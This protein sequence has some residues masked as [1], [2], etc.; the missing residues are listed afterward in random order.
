M[1]TNVLMIVLCVA[2][3]AFGNGGPFVLKYPGGDPAAKGVLARLGPGLLPG[4][5]T[6]LEVVKEDLSVTSG[7]ERFGRRHGIA[8]PPLATVEA[9]YHIRNPLAE[10]VE[11]DFGFPI[12]R[13]IY[14]SPYSMM[15]MP[16]VN[17]KVN[18]RHVQADVISN[19][20]IYGIIR[21]QARDVIDRASADDKT[22]AGLVKQARKAGAGRKA[23]AAR[24]ALY[25]H[26]VESRKW[27]TRDATL[28]VEYTAVDLGTTAVDVPG[29]PWTWFRDR[30]E[31]RRVGK[32][33]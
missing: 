2:G 21:R 30:S 14:I 26:L 1:K 31:E 9:A 5:E 6:R 19:S 23:P 12:L 32:E 18:G 29:R 16:A 25:E 10:E 20:A 27:T 13:G 4:R 28:L 22:L 33:C 3:T 7:G 11:V 15:P 24:S 8:G 17:V